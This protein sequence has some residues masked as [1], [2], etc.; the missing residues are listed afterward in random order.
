MLYKDHK[1]VPRFVHEYIVAL[2]FVGR[3]MKTIC[4]NSI[5]LCVLFS[6]WLLEESINFYTSIQ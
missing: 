5:L 2:P 1:A 4:L 3:N 6:V